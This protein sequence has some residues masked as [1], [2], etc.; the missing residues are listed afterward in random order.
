MGLQNIITYNKD[1]R[2]QSSNIKDRFRL[3]KE[4][5]LLFFFPSF[6]TIGCIMDDNLTIPAILVFSP[7]LHQI[8]GS[9]KGHLSRSSHCAL[10]SC[11]CCH[12]FLSQGDSGGPLNCFTDGDWRVHGVV[13]YGPSG[14][15]NQWRK[16]TVFTRVSSFL[17]WIY[18]VSFLLPI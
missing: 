11:V 9:V 13:S 16:P 6:R 1:T 3:N 18:S 5:V 8:S 2:Y 7:V 10:S 4:T 17:D 15:C 14:F 12:C